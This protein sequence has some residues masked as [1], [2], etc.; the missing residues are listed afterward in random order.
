MLLLRERWLPALPW[1]GDPALTP[2]LGKC[3]G[4]Q[5]LLHTASGT[6][7]PA[8]H[9]VSAAVD[10]LAGGRCPFSY[11]DASK[12]GW[13]GTTKGWWEPAVGGGAERSTAHSCGYLCPSYSRTLRWISSHITLVSFASDQLLPIPPFPNLFHSFAS[14]S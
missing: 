5:P 2:R 11:V 6:P 9:A 8:A 4:T 10:L 3:S 14:R 13:A 12:Q 7:G 1:E